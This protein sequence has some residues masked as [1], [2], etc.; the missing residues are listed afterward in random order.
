MSRYKVLQIGSTRAYSFKGSDGDDVQMV[1]HT[2]EVMDEQK[3]QFEAIVARPP[4][5]DGPSA[6]EVLEGY[7]PKTDKRGNVRLKKAEQGGFSGGGGGGGGREPDP[8]RQRSIVRQHSQEMALR[9][10]AIR[11][12]E[13]T[14]A[15]SEVAAIADFFERD[16]N[17]EPQTPDTSDFGPVPSDVPADT[18]GLQP[19]KKIP[20]GDDDIPF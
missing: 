2:I 6:G 17:G 13:K 1:D 11:A 7:A 4:T 15:L 18:E 16:A 8:E 9:Y 10:A 19:I 12:S 5:T 3:N 20:G 14:F